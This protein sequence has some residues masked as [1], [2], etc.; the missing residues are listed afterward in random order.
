MLLKKIV[1]IGP[2]STG[3]ST[4]CEQLAA[5]YNTQWVPE[6]AREFLNTYGTNYTFENLGEIA[7]GQLEGEQLAI[8][9]MELEFG[10]IHYGAAKAK[11]LFIDTDLYVMKVWSEI[12]FNKCDN[13][14]LTQ[15]TQRSYDLYLLCN[16]DLPWVKDSLREYPDLKT[17]EKIYHHYK[18]A[19]LNQNTEWV[20]I[21]G[22]YEQRFLKAVSAVDKLLISESK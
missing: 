13:K 5:H 17:R 2:E 8:N 18:D 11:P 20:D 22:N 15:I 9:N 16:T 7:K 10:N 14:I 1:I 21:S 12:V 3:K 6:Y 19:M 4:L